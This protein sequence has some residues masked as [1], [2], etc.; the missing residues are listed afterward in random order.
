MWD[1]AVQNPVWRDKRLPPCAPGAKGGSCWR[2]ETSVL[3]FRVAKTE[4]FFGWWRRGEGFQ[5]GF[6]Q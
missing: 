5:P 3:G 2:Q 6:T 1:L 4:H